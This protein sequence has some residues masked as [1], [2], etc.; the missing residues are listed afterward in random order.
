MAF[1]SAL[2]AQSPSGSVNDWIDKKPP[3]ERLAWD[4]SWDLGMAHDM[5]ND[6]LLQQ[7][8]S[9]DLNS[10][11]AAA[12]KDALDRLQRY[13]SQ[14]KIP[15]ILLNPDVRPRL[16]RGLVPVMRVGPLGLFTDSQVPSDIQHLL[17]Q[18]I[19]DLGARRSGYKLAGQPVQLGDAADLEALLAELDHNREA[20]DAKT[21]ADNVA[22]LSVDE[23]Q[24]KVYYA[25]YERLSSALDGKTPS[26][27]T[28]SYGFGSG[29][30]TSFDTF[31][32]LAPEWLAK[33]NIIFIYCPA[34]TPK[35]AL[36]SMP[37][38]ARFGSYGIWGAP[39]E[40]EA[41][42]RKLEQ[43]ILTVTK[44]EEF[45]EEAHAMGIDQFGGATD[46][47]QLVAATQER[48]A[49]G[50]AATAARSAPAPAPKP[51]VVST[52]AAKPPASSFGA[53]LPTVPSHAAS[54]GVAPPAHVANSRGPSSFASGTNDPANL[55]CILDARN[56]ERVRKVLEAREAARRA[57]LEAAARKKI[58]LKS[59]AERMADVQRE[60]EA[61]ARQAREIAAWMRSEQEKTAARWRQGRIQQQ[62]QQAKDNAEVLRS[63]AIQIRV[64][65]ENGVPR[66][67]IR[68]N[69]NI[70]LQ[71]DWEYA[72]FVGHEEKR[73]SWTTVVSDKD[74][75]I[76]TIPGF[77]D[78]ECRQLG[79][80]VSVTNVHWVKW[81]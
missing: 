45:L 47:Q 21:R 78:D 23:R 50:K 29:P 52:S 27:L 53:P 8:V 12:A 31:R 55:G 39:S 10:D 41:N 20:A 33:Y 67:E 77:I 15:F 17:V 11:P 60:K 19:R 58:H 22:K 81:N 34:D 69:T 79:Y 75:V 1:A 73:G 32:K 42:L 6:P 28:Y 14:G 57:K 51:A 64:I 7:N 62:Q 63:D 30:E 24:S 38:V 72:G 43:A 40:S 48:P 68:N 16:R 80:T 70:W 25:L 26:G 4:V 54:S 66:V 2:H 56:L 37:P 76:A 44:D 18:S 36:Q 74:T 71:V 49:H 9:Y 65:S 13:R 46:L 35:S 61:R 3:L 5:S 59:Y